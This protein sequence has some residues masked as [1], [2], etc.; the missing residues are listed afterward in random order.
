MEKVFIK[1][2]KPEHFTIILPPAEDFILNYEK[3]CDLVESYSFEVEG[4]LQF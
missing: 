1:E 2:E 4:L 3:S